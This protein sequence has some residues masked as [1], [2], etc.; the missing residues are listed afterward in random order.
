MTEHVQAVEITNE[1]G[2]HARA[3][4]EFVKLAGKFT[5]QVFVKKDEQEVNGKS[6][7]G[8]LMLVAAFG[9]TI[10]IRAVGDDAK[11]AVSQLVQL[12]KDG[13]YEDDDA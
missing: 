1:R 10:E 11:D 12:V 7:M 8:V 3:A 6:I 2:L 5:S 13:F 4:S 9:T